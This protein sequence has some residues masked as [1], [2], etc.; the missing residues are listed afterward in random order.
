[1]GIGSG[2]RDEAAV[3]FGLDLHCW[4]LLLAGLSPTA[5]HGMLIVRC[6]WRR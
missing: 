3:I 1:M 6:L 2:C 5:K 4:L